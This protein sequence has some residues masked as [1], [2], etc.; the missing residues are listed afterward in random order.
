MQLT[1]RIML[2]TTAEQEEMLRRTMRLT[3]ACCDYMSGLAFDNKVFGRF[4]L[5]R[6]AY[7]QTRDAFPA[8]ASQVVIRAIAKVAD[9]YD[10]DRERLRTF[11]P[12]GAISYD[13]R[14]LSFRLT[15]KSVS[16]WTISGRLKIPF[17][18][19]PR[20][21][22]LLHGKRG[23]ADL[24]L[25]GERFYLF[26]SCEVEAPE[27]IDVVDVLGVDMGIVN[28]ASDSDGEAFSGDAVEENR[29][30]FAHRRRNLQRN[31][32]A[33]ARRKLRS[34]SGKQSRFQKNTNHRI[35]KRIVQKAQDTNRAIALEDLS[36]I[37]GRVTVRRQQRARHTNWSFFDLQA[38]IMYKARLAGVPVI[39][40]DPRNTSKMCS[41]CGHVASA[42][43]PN[44]SSFKCTRCGFADFADH[45]AAVNIAARAAVIQPMVSASRLTVHG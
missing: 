37:G 32:S 45:N 3:N 2:D 27:L 7:R 20:Q 15:S 31:G 16:I 6:F 43:R 35:S 34:I 42:N 28:L 14:I 1:S 25:I 18:C 40:V 33:S 9:A 44:R 10:H 29:R 41:V 24:C 36:G 12:E 11:K 30:I 38:K 13:S 22:E 8:L 5:Q 26:V 21:L 17:R 23:E 19:G 39:M 4:S